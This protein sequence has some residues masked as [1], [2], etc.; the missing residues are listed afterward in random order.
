MNRDFFDSLKNDDNKKY[1]KKPFNYF[2]GIY[3]RSSAEREIAVLYTELGIPFKYE[4]TI[5]LAGMVP[6]L[7][8]LFTYD[9][10]EMP[11]DIRYLLSKLNSAVYGTSIIHIPGK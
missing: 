9:T 4:P 3:Y 2:N 7:D 11:F 6:D 1:P 5:K 8:I 10:D